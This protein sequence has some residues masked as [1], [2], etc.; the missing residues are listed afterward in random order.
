MVFGHGIREEKT[1]YMCE[2]EREKER[3]RENKAVIYERETKVTWE[4]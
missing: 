1:V 2:L 3:E 4:N